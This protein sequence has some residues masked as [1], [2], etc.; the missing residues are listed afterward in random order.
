MTAKPHP[1]ESRSRV[2]ILDSS[3]NVRI[4]LETKLVGR[5][6]GRIYRLGDSVGKKEPRI[7]GDQLGKGNPAAKAK[8][9]SMERALS[10]RGKDPITPAADFPSPIR[11]SGWA[12]QQNRAHDRND[13]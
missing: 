8:P 11:M 7:K 13:R 1:R 10:P 2:D 3:Q 4:E 5:R 9:C 6:G 12:R